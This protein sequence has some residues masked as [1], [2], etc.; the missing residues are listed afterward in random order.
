M[1]NSVNPTNHHGCNDLYY[2]PFGML[3]PGRNSHAGDYRFG[4]NGKENDN[5]VKGTGNQQD[6]G[7]RIYDSRLGRFL[8]VDPLSIDYPWY[9]PYQF[10]GNKPI[11]FID[12]DGKEEYDPSNDPYFIPKLILTTFFDIKHSAENI[13]LKTVSAPPGFKWEAGYKTDENGNEIFETQFRLVPFQSVAKEAWNTGLDAINVLGGGK[14]NPSDILAAK[15]QSNQVTKALRY[16]LKATDLD[17]RGQEVNFNKTLE[18]AFEQ[19]GVNRENFEVTQWGKTK[20]GKSIPV[21]YRAEGGAEVSIDFGHTTNGPEVPHVG[22][23]TAGKGKDSSSGHILLDD[24]PAG[25]TN[26]KN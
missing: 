26:K 24:I 6:Y 4:F 2:Y 18:K 5:E 12:L 21:E 11:K 8:S 16:E 19:T 3:M 15:T 1:V 14:L 25:R 17:L 9:T 7:M 20:D 23:Q 10:A 13:L 22:W